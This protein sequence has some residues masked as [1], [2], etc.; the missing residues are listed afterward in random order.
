LRLNLV[1]I[2]ASINLYALAL[3]IQAAAGVFS[4]KFHIAIMTKKNEVPC[5]CLRL[6]FSPRS[7]SP[8]I[9][10]DMCV[11]PFLRYKTP[12]GGR[13]LPVV[14]LFFAAAFTPGLAGPLFGLD[15]PVKRIV[16]DS[17]LRISLKDTWFTEIPG[18]ALGRRAE[19]F[20]LGGGGRVQ[21]RT[22]AGRDE[23]MII[24]A[25]ETGGPLGLSWG[26]FP[27][28]AQGSWI[29]TR[30]KD[31]GEAA[32]IRVFLRSDPYTYVQFRPLSDD[33]CQMDVVVYDAYILRSLPLPVPL[34][35]LYTM[36]VEEA[37]SLAGD[38]FPRRYFEPDPAN[39][40]DVRNFIAQVRSRIPELTFAD[41]GAL[42]EKGNYVYIGTLEDQDPPGGLNCSG[43]AKWVVDGILRPLTGERLPIGPLKEPFGQRGSSFTE[44]WE[45][46]R[47]PFFG[48]DWTRQL[49]S[50]AM[51]ALR[52][53][54]YG[55]LEEI[56]VQRQPFSQVIVRGQNTSALRAYPGF[57][58][59][60]GYG[61]EG[62][63]PLL[64]TLAI[65][66][67]GRVYLAS[68]NTELGP[69]ATEE[70]PR[71]RP[72]MRQHFHIAV[73]VPF[74]NEYGNFQVAVFESA[75]E[76]SFTSFKTRYPAHAVN[77]VRIP[78]ESSFDP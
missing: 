67:P 76:T 29:L 45:S 72:R 58:K 59:D 2:E 8:I 77:L 17:S 30:R 18:R 39:Y 38:K 40:R 14:C 61:F 48:L 31:T 26:A 24:L 21:V 63:H 52:S 74:F 53:S 13:A 54:A 46:V 10:T 12:R 70:N 75:G 36:P 32:R 23:F 25:R 6:R 3:G 20:T 50:R 5:R 73:L 28:W 62:L 49:A 65:D 9:E 47:D 15:L 27:G 68:V 33:K 56:E 1:F 42:D 60:A 16:D 69:P 51:T 66:E 78:V 71:G 55:G 4:Y 43:F 34:E 41:D 37:L 7:F 19:L 44:P 64:Y 11:A 35:R 57:L 22:E